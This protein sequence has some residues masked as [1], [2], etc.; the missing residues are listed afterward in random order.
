MRCKRKATKKIQRV[1]ACQCKN[2]GGF[3]QKLSEEE[4]P[5]KSTL[6]KLNLV[7]RSP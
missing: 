5:G 2:P 6:G 4:D 1:P 3:I 7:G